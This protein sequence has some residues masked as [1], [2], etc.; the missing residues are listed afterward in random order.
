MCLA[1]GQCP[2]ARLRGE[3]ELVENWAVASRGCRCSLTG[4]GSQ[5]HRKLRLSGLWKTFCRK[6]ALH[7]R[8]GLRFLWSS[9]HTPHSLW[10]HDLFFLPQGKYAFFL[11]LWCP[12]CSILADISSHS[13]LSEE[14]WSVIR[15]CF[16]KHLG[17]LS[18]QQGIWDKA[19]EL[20]LGHHEWFYPISGLI[21]TKTI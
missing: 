18:S 11:S 4:E 15:T 19:G 13:C 14:A 17:N 1:P 5:A 9:E 7:E 6:A 10:H 3:Q 20:D 16:I 8:E 21:V 12:E 2:K